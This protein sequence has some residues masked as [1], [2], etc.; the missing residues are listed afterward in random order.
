VK[1]VSS[2]SLQKGVSA[3]QAAASTLPL[4]DFTAELWRISRERWASPSGC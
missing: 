3:A 1:G 4:V 2:V